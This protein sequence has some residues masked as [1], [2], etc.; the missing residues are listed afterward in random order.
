M[1]MIGAMAMALALAAQAQ[2]LAVLHTFTGGTDGAKP[3]GLAMDAAGNLY[4]TTSAG[5]SAGQCTGYG[6]CGVVSREMSTARHCR[7]AEAVASGKAA[8]WCGS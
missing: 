3:I 4:G 5:G 2:T 6:G 8:A 1:A 7:V